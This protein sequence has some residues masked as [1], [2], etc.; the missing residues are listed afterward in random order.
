MSNIPATMNVIE[1]SKP[2]APD[3]LLPAQ[4]PVPVPKAGEV[5]VK[6]AATL[7]PSY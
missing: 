4:R 2:G 5:L 1:I 3:V 6:V 7:P